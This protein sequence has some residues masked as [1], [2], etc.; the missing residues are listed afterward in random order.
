MLRLSTSKHPPRQTTA[1]ALCW[2]LSRPFPSSG[3][4]MEIV[5]LLRPICDQSG[6]FEHGSDNWRRSSENGD[7]RRFSY[8]LR[9]RDFSR[10]FPQTC[11]TL[12]AQLIYAPTARL[13]NSRTRTCVCGGPAPSQLVIQQHS[14]NSLKVRSAYSWDADD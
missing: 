1:G 2:S 9:N 7:L 11:A 10:K 12:L 8:N 4:W 14:E 13:A 5:F 3:A 6:G